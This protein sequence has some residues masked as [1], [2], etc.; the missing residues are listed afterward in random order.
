MKI[1]KRQ[2]RRIIKEA[3]GAY[4]IPGAVRMW[5]GHS[6]GTSDFK[7]VLGANLMS[8]IE[9]I[10]TFYHEQPDDEWTAGRAEEIADTEMGQTP[11]IML[12]KDGVLTIDIEGF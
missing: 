4:E 7:V 6:P 11:T 2:L 5:K 3:A 1:T 10:Q 8:A 12:T 9:G